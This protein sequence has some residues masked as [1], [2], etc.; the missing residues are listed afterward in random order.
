M[1]RPVLLYDGDCGFCTASVRFIDRHIPTR[2]RIMP[3]QRADL[4]AL[5]VTASRASREVLWVDERGRVSGAAQAVARLLTAA[6]GAWRPVGLL[7]RTPP[8]RWIA[9]AAYRFVSK[10]RDRLPGGTPA[11]ALPPG[12]APGTD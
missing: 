5:G 3:Y 12:R 7:L 4:A 1:D 2:A 11:C 6:G 8:L 10:H 9:L